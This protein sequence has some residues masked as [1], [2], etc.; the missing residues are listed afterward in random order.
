MF[1]VDLR[2]GGLGLGNLL[3]AKALVLFLTIF[4]LIFVRLIE[5]SMICIRTKSYS[6]W[7][8]NWV[9]NAPISEAFPLDKTSWTRQ[10]LLA[11]PIIPKWPLLLLLFP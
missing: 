10:N 4:F 8:D 3:A 5:A 1:V 9:R 2:R 7:E 6:F 11:L